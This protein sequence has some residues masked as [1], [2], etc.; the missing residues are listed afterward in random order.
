MPQRKTTKQALKR[1]L[2]YQARFN[3]YEVR[4][5]K[6]L[7]KNAGLSQVEYARRRLLEMPIAELIP[8]VPVTLPA[9]VIGRP[10]R[11]MIRFNAKEMRECQKRAKEA[12][13]S[14]AEYARSKILSRGISR[15][16]ESVT[17]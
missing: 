4:I 15:S 12:G 8:T 17:T 10:I 9:D 1:S 11:F 3:S 16:V 14:Q 6:T 2:R 5:L 13:Q 7:S